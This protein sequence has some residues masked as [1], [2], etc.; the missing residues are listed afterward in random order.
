MD[1][2]EKKAIAILK[3]ATKEIEK[4]GID[5]TF[6][7]PSDQRHSFVK[8]EFLLTNTED[9]KICPKCKGDG[10]ETIDDEYGGSMYKC[11]KCDGHKYLRR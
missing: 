3:K 10:I 4:L 1:K 8:V 2:N 11:S 6:W 5:V 7:G 9:W